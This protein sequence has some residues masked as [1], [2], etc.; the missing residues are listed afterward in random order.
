[1]LFQPGGPYFTANSSVNVSVRPYGSGTM[2]HQ[3]IDLL[4]IVKKVSDPKSESGLGLQ[5]PLIVR[6]PDVLKN[7]LESSREL[8]ILRS[9]PRTT[10]P[11]TRASTR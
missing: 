5:L 1:M 4:K 3:E 6:F 9:S 10:G 2:P 8:L 7:R 11:T